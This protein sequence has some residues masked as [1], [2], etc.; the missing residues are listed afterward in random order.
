MLLKIKYR[1]FGFDYLVCGA[2]NNLYLIPHFR[3]RRTV[4]FTKIKPF[5]NKKGSDKKNTIKYH[6]TNVSFKQLREKKIKVNETI[7][8]Y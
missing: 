2:D 1:Y 5:S 8:V 4:Y 6:G 3:Y 7:N